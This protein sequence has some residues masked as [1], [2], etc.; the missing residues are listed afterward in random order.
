MEK[1]NKRDLLAYIAATYNISVQEARTAYDMVVNSIVSQVG[2]GT[3]VSLM[4]FGRF[5]LQQHKG[6][7]IQFNGE[8]GS[9]GNYSVFK[10]SASNALNHSI[11]SAAVK[12]A[13]L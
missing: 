6:H 4:G 12:D 2:A 7:P 1:M 13:A 9:V 11:R 10:F 3:E 5:Y 8:T